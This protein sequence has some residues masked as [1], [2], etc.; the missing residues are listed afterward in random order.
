MRD[1]VP[2]TARQA[3]FIPAERLRVG[4]LGM[5]LDNA[6]A[7]DVLFSLDQKSAFILQF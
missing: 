4:L 1:P 3:A 2:R 7:H 6:F 5:K